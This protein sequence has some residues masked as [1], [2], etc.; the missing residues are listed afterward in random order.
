MI[1]PI[2]LGGGRNVMIDKFDAATVLELMERE[3]IAYMFMVPTMLNGLVRHP[4][5][6]AHD[7]SAL[8]CVVIAAAPIADDTALKGHEAFGNALYQL[9][10]QTEVLP[11][12]VMTGAQWF[13]TDVPGSNPLRAC[14]MP[15]PFAELEIWD[16]DNKPVAPGQPGQ[17]VA[18]S[19]GQMSGFWNDPAGTKERM[20]DGWVLTGDVGMLDTNGYLYMLDRLND[21]IVSGGYNIYPA[22]LENVL[23]SHPAVVE[24]AVFGVPHDK[25]GEAPIAVCTIDPKLAVTEQELIQLCADRLGSYKKPQ[26]VEFRREPL[27]KTP[28]GKIKRKELREPFWQGHTRRI[29]G[30]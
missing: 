13:R 28:V 30:S 19:D 12:A 22:E 10:G 21:M 17:I 23:A 9:Y 27:P 3:K 11:V 1:T 8:K 15:L 24:V 29:A 14:G 25:W 16:E 2:W 5:I 26:R 20:V 6:A 18:K 7:F 4:A